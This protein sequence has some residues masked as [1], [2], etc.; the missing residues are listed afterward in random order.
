MC[1][2]FLRAMCQ[3]LLLWVLYRDP[4]CAPGRS[5][6]CDPCH[7]HRRVHR[8]VLLHHGVH[9]RYR[10]A[11]RAWHDLHKHWDDNIRMR[12][13]LHARAFLRR[14]AGAGASM[15]R[16]WVLVS[17]RLRERGRD[18]MWCRLLRHGRR[19]VVHER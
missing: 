1:V 15:Q 11:L 7:T 12:R 17:S 16:K 18:C 4:T 9:V 6:S 14:R 10:G 19:R 8:G 5:H 3:L 13:P 2:R